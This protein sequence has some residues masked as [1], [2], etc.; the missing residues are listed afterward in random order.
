MSI[1]KFP[2]EVPD[3]GVHCPPRSVPARRTSSPTTLSFPRAS[4]PRLFS[5]KD[6][7][8]M[9]PPYPPAILPN[10]FTSGFEFTSLDR[11]SLASPF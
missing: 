9:F 7:A 3:V 1:S 5:F 4:A 11:P 2:G 10:A 8:L 6:F